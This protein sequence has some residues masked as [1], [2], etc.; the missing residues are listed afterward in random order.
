MLLRLATRRLFY[1][2][3]GNTYSVAS[4]WTLWHHPRGHSNLVYFALEAH[5]YA[6][7][8]VQCGFHVSYF[9]SLVKPIRVGIQYILVSV[10]R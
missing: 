1:T 8:I 6:T 3:E 2:Y 4:I 7:C 10:L 5:L 9:G